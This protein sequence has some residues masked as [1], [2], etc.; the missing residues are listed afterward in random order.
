M[1]DTNLAAIPATAA[2]LLRNLVTSIL[3]M[4]RIETTITKCKATQP[5]VEK[6]IT[7]GKRGTVHARRQALSYLMTPECVDRLF[8]VVAPRY[9]DRN[10]G[11]TRIT[12]SRVRQ[13]DAAEMAY[14]ELLGAEQ[15]LD[16]KREKREAARA[17]KRE[18]IAKQM[19]EQ[20]PR[21]RLARLP[22]TRMNPKPRSNRRVDDSDLICRSA[23]VSIARLGHFCVRRA[24]KLRFQKACR[25]RFCAL[26]EEL[27]ISGDW[28]G[29]RSKG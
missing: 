22:Q 16:A 21:R 13:G 9:G 12:R 7:L 5:L 1:Q 24:E 23:Q 17:K 3:L 27:R 15:E 28:L 6:M 18:E 11:Y 8:N 29:F 10:G 26:K 4:D 25:R 2:P 20:N 14:I 19:E